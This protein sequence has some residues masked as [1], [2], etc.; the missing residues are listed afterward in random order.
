M[1]APSSDSAAIRQIIR[2]LRAAGYALDT[3]SAYGE[4]IVVKNED[5]AIK[6]ITD[7][8]DAWLYVKDSE[9]FYHGVYFVL[10]NAP[11]EVAADWHVSLSHVIDPLTESWWWT[12]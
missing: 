4:H 7:F 9:G 11:E 3:V 1:S 10:G 6:E 12:D 8:D 5:E 2:A